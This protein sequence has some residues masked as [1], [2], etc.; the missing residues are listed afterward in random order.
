MRQKSICSEKYLQKAVT[1]KSF[2]SGYEWKSDRKTEEPDGKACRARPAA[3]AR[4]ESKAPPHGGLPSA[5]HRGF[6][7]ALRRQSGHLLVP[8]AHGKQVIPRAAPSRDGRAVREIEIIHPVHMHVVNIRR[9]IR[10]LRLVPDGIEYSRCGKIPANRLPE[11]GT[12]AS[13]RR[14]PQKAALRVKG[15]REALQSTQR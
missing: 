3:G 10:D 1:S 8:C 9:H 5:P 7:P 14:V 2:F 13:A 4:P 15:R 6:P 12:A 11:Y